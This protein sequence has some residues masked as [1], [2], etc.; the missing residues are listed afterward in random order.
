MLS[1]WTLLILA[2]CTLLN[3]HLASSKPTRARP[4]PPP[5]K[6]TELRA[7]RALRPLRTLNRTSLSSRTTQEEKEVQYSTNWAGAVLDPL[8]NSTY[9]FVSATITVPTPTPTSSSDS[10]SDSDS[11]STYQAASAWLGI[12]GATYATAILQTGIDIYV[13]DGEGY[14]DAWYE[15]YP[16]FARYFDEFAVLPGDV[17]VASVNAS[18]TP[19]ANG[20][21]GGADHG[22]CIMENLTSG[23]S[24]TTTVSAP[25]STAT[26]AGLNAEWVVEDYSSG[27][28]AVPFVG[29]GEVR[30]EG[31]A[32]GLG[33]GR[34]V[35]LDGEQMEVYELV[36]GG[37]VAAGVEVGGDGVVVTREGV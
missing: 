19:D 5:E 25:K 3:L 6:L 11:A 21:S 12:D 26:L 20:R 31:C 7:H 1:P 4:R 24:V 9:A 32:A 2:L 23:E 14:T 27:G 30:F 13:I 8:P 35:G 33:D 18:F 17:L 36:L 37:V 15:W 34:E 29:F 28:E 22:V 16:D 10:D